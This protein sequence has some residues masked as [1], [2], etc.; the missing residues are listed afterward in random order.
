M[1]EGDSGNAMLVAE[2]VSRT[3]H[4]ASL[5]HILLQLPRE[6]SAGTP[7]LVA[8]N[9]CA[10]N[11]S[12]TKEDCKNRTPETGTEHRTVVAAS[13]K[14]QQCATVPSGGGAHGAPMFTETKS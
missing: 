1:S 11:M 12:T 5:L 3:V 14:K 2:Q 10:A 6:K 13:E 4:V 7:F 8:V 9:K